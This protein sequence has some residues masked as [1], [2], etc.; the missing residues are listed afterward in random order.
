MHRHSIRPAAP[1][2]ASVPAN[3]RARVLAGALALLF[4][5]CAAP[6]P[7]RAAP[8][9]GGV[10]LRAPSMPR[11]ISTD[12][13]AALAARSG[14][15]PPLVVDM[16]TDV[17]SYLRAHIPGA[18]YL[19][20]ETLRVGS[21]GVPNLVLPAASYRTLLGRLGVRADR[22]V[23]VHSSGES[24]NIDA[25]YLA[26]ILAG[27]G[28]PSVHLLD[29][30]FAK[31]EAEGRPTTRDYPALD[32]TPLAAP[33]F[34][35]E[36]AT[37]EEIRASLGRNTLLL[38]DARP[39]DQYRGDAGAQMRR[40]HIPGAVNHHW[41]TDLAEEGGFGLVFKGVDALR[42]SYAA[43]G[44]TPDRD[45]VVYCNGGLESSHVYFALRSLLGY[46]KVRVYDGSW[47]EWA[48]RPELPMARGS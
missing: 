41:A 22:P 40:G 9:P 46:P 2:R 48:A 20:S 14:G 12:S 25:T 42:A 3:G 11:L 4:A 37:L 5:G 17:G 21:G 45:I 35:L 6:R 43:Q 1:A 27:F 18:V 29:G 13:L 7:P 26:W 24:R 28:H 44:I 23:V 33:T 47:T 32:T 10:Q 16:R 39:P 30:G 15:A 31:W 8:G 36:R 38:V 34:A 19:N